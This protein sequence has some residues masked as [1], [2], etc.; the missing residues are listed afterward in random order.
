MWISQKR[1][2]EDERLF[3]SSDC[4]GRFGRR[5]WRDCR[6]DMKTGAWKDGK[7]EAG[8]EI[9]RFVPG[10]ERCKRDSKGFRQEGTSLCLKG[11]GS[12]SSL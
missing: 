7:N 12:S 11:E 1:M 8:G 2:V 6:W 5:S 4:K 9:C 3:R 10:S